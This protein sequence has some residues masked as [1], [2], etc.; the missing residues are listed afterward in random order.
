MTTKN[1]ACELREDLENVRFMLDNPFTRFI[2]TK[3]MLGDLRKQFTDV[4]ARSVVLG[5][6]GTIELMLIHIEK[7]LGEDTA[8]EEESDTF[9]DESQDDN[10]DE[11]LTALLKTLL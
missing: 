3:A 10:L 5:I 9:D 8:A 11:L 1:T 4:E 6:S 2:L 7:I